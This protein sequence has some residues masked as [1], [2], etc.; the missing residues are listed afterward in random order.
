MILIFNDLRIVNIER[1]AIFLTQVDGIDA[2][3]AQIV[4]A[5]HS[6]Y[7]RRKGIFF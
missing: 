4:D 1:S 3:K 7:L 6:Y 5:V 2:L